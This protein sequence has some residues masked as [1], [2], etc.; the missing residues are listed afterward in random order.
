MTVAEALELRKSTRAFLNKQVDIEIIQHILNISRH[1]PSGVNTQPWQVAVVSGDK[2]HEVEQAMENAFNS[3]VKG[4]M[5]YQYYPNK[6]QEPYKNRR[7]FCGLQ[8][9]STLQIARED[10]DKQKQQWL[11]NY[12][13]FD[14]PVVLFFF[15]DEMMETGSFLDYGM[16]LQ[17]I[18]L[19]AVE[20]GLAT[21]PQAALAEYPQ[22][23]KEKLN[24]PD[25]CILICG[26]AL[27]Y[28]DK[29]A[30][31]NSYRTPREEVDSF[32]KFF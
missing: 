26:M 23:I 18:M 11:A 30:V 15:M 4:K 5:D 27:G 19:A 31:I 3:G 32:T 7:K 13:A 25:E 6:W 16:F 2:K 21:C 8:L 9:Y 10:K 24:Y 29:E 17:S 12:R 14:A 28:E 1:A 22:I 20:E